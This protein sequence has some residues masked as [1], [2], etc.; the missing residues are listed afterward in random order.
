MTQAPETPPFDDDVE[1]GFG[2]ADLLRV[3]SRHWRVIA[4]TTA[5]CAALT[6]QFML[7]MPNQYKATATVQVSQGKNQVLDAD[8]V[9]KQIGGDSASVESEVEVMRSADLALMVIAHLKLRSD[10][11]FSQPGLLASLSAWLGMSRTTTSD[12]SALRPSIA[13]GADGAMSGTNAP[14]FVTR[15]VPNESIRDYLRERT[16]TLGVPARDTMLQAFRSRFKAGR[17]RNSL[18]IEVEFTSSD[19]LKSADVNS[20][21]IKSE[22]RTRPALNRLR[23]A[24]SIVSRAGTPSVVV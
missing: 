12:A 17:V 15:R 18:L 2:L 22:L 5:T 4:I 6:A 13:P 10:P 23:N 20:T 11:E 16:T 1:D 19:P 24:C 7:M 14:A 9:I 8:A 3:L 21:S